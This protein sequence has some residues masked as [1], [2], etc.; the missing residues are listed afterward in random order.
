MGYKTL[1]CFL[2]L[3]IVSISGILCQEETKLNP[4]YIVDEA[5]RTLIFKAKPEKAEIGLVIP[6]SFMILTGSKWL[7]DASV[8]KNIF[9]ERVTSGG[10]GAIVIGLG[11]GMLYWIYNDHNRVDPQTDTPLIIL[12]EEGL[13]HEGWKSKI[14]WTNIEH[15]E[16]VKI[17]HYTIHMMDHGTF[18]T[19]NGFSWQIKLK[20]KQQK[21]WLLDERNIQELHIPAP[22]NHCGPFNYDKYGGKLGYLI[23]QYYDKYK[24]EKA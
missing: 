1:F 22:S 15:I 6:A 12:D 5:G 23:L 24:R 20:T 9:K 2:F 3:T 19:Y 17:H 13:W 7:Y 14:P 18:E 8:S 4:G 11:A 10:I 16:F 21:T